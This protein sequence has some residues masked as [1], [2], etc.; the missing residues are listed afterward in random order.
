MA[1]PGGHELII[2]RRHEEDE[3]EHHSSAWKVAHA[4]F[5]TAMMAFFLIMW[6]INVTDD[7]VRKGISEYFNPIHMSE[8]STELK[9][10]NSV[11][12]QASKSA[13]K[14]HSDTPL[15][16]EALNL[17]KLA[18]GHAEEKTVTEGQHRRQHRSLLLTPPT[19]VR[20]L[21]Q[22]SRKVQARLGRPPQMNTPLFRTHTRCWRSWRMRM[23]RIIPEGSM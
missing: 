9:G 5:M 16:D 14:G 11:D 13:K 22:R 2:V 18:A 7:Q 8:G 1:D 3:H 17:M 15:P 21:R 19:R 23:W 4:D 6:L 20:R 10:L 12:Q